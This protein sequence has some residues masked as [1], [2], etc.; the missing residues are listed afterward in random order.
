MQNSAYVGKTDNTV[1]N[2]TKQHGW[3]QSDSALRKHFDHCEA[4]EEIVKVFQSGGL[5]IDRMSFLINSVRKDTE[6]IH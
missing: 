4:L 2:R 1:S 3:L 6:T 5:E